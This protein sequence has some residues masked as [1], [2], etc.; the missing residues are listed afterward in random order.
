MIGSVRMRS[1]SARL[2]GERPAFWQRLCAARAHASREE[3]QTVRAWRE[4]GRY[5]RDQPVP[6]PPAAEVVWRNVRRELRLA[7][8]EQRPEGAAWRLFG[9]R[10][11]WGWAT[12]MASLALVAVLSWQG[13]RAVAVGEKDA[14]E[15][16]VKWVESAWPGSPTMVYEDAEIGV[17]VI[18]VLAPGGSSQNGSA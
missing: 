8:A 18:W 9:W 2:D 12:A 4:I 5:L 13:I 14:G 17:V 6:T 11:A 7:S 16:R 3:E 1:A 10:V 15:G